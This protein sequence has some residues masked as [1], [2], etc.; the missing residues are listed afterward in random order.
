MARKQAKPKQA[1]PARQSGVPSIALALQGGGSHGAFTWGVLDRL[2]DEV[3]QNRLKFTAVSGASAGAINAALLASGLTDGVAAARSSLRGFWESLSQGPAGAANML[4]F[5]EPSP[6]G[7]WNIDFEPLALAAEALS[8]VVSPYGNPFYVDALAPRLEA[9]L[10]ADQLARLNAPE[11]IPTFISATNVRDTERAIFTQP[12]LSIDALRA[13]ACVPTDFRAVTI[14]GVPYWDGG[15]LGNPPLAPLVDRSQDLML[16][17][18]NPFVR[19]DSPP[20]SAPAIV[21]RLNE[22]TFNAS[23]VLELNGIDVVNRVLAGFA[24]AGVA[25]PTSYRTTRFHCI[26][27]DPFLASLGFLSKNSTSAALIAALFQHGRD[28]AAAWLAA[29][30]DLIGQASSYD[31]Y[32]DLIEPVLGG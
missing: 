4:I 17:L 28:A 3:A 14:A 29:N 21:G 9:A 15:Y 22:I 5:A 30:Y 32:A 23:V 8:L 1:L 24:A 7:G 6:F 26:R 10:P 11:A 16:V 20:T 18:L 2:L 25:N 31:V 13:S 12:Q 27:N 19:T